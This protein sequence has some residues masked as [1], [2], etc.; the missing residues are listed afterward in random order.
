MLRVSVLGAGGRMGT[1]LLEA[2]GDARD[3][4]LA[5]ALV[6]PGSDLVGCTAG[7]TVTFT[8]QPV[9]A[10]DGADVAIDFT[11]PGA[12][13][14]NLNACRDAGVPVVIGTTGLTPAQQGRMHDVARELPIVWSPNMSVGVNLCFRLAEIAARVLDNDYDAEIIDIHHRHKR[15]APSGTALK[16]GEIIAAARGQR[17]EKVAE[18]RGPRSDR[19]RQRGAIG[20]AAVRAGE[21]VGE[22]T[23]MFVGPGEAIEL[24]HSAA[25][26]GAFATGAVRAA[27]WLHG[28]GAGLYTM[29]QVLG[30]DD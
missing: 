5:G 11:L 20:F 23:V 16:F 29:Y 13:N 26:R 2:I 27:R 10:L 28:R 8:D 6:R 19:P 9:G 3:I 30:L 7:P 17:L 4:A 18:H 15:D 22:H 14:S 1:A 25:Q 12:F 24:R 21:V